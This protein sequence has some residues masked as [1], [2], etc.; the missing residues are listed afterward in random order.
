MKNN[1]SLETIDFSDNELTDFHGLLI[2]GLIKQ[3]SERRDNELWKLS[4]RETESEEHLK[5]RQRM[6]NLSNTETKT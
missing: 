6:L 2:L 1:M 5:L 4:L 3:Q